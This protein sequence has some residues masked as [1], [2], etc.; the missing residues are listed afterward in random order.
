MITLSQI[1]IDHYS[2][3]RN[4]VDKDLK[5]R[6]DAGLDRPVSLLAAYR[7]SFMPDNDKTVYLGVEI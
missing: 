4:A 1:I 5:G 6:V 2:L 7:W 3:P